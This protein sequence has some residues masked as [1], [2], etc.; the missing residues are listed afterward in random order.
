MQQEQEDILR[1]IFFNDQRNQL[2]GIDDLEVLTGKSSG[3]LRPH[4]EDLKSKQLIIENRRK[5][6]LSK[7]GRHHCASL[8]V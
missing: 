2:L 5:L 4:L 7:E 1:E 6:E 8:W 3:E